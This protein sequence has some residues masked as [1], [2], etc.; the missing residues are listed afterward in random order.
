VLAVRDEFTASCLNYVV[1][2]VVIRRMRLETYTQ[3]LSLPPM[4]VGCW[5]FQSRPGKQADETAA[6]ACFPLRRMRGRGEGGNLGGASRPGSAGELRHG[7]ALGFS[8]T[9]L[10]TWALAA[11]SRVHYLPSDLRMVVV[12]FQVCKLHACMNNPL[13]RISGSRHL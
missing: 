1:P 7:S 11:V 4:T 9:A 3:K 13:C 5:M 8:S 12:L 6:L 10:P 2:V